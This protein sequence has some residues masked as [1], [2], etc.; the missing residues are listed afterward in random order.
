MPVTKLQHAVES[1]DQSIQ[2]QKDESGHV[3]DERHSA[4]LMNYAIGMEK[5]R[6]QLKA[7]LSDEEPFCTEIIEE[8]MF[9]ELFNT[10]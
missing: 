6:A 10:D 7:Y 8:Q 5:A 1:I 4:R 2:Y 9:D 3:A